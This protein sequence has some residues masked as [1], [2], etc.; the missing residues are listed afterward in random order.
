MTNSLLIECK[1]KSKMVNF[2]LD[3]KYM[4]KLQVTIEVFKLLQ[5]DFVI[6]ILFSCYCN[7]KEEQLYTLISITLSYKVNKQKLIIQI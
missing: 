7:W 3:V 2:M 1:Q 6:C 5:L 4:P